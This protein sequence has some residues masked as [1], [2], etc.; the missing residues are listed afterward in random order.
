MLEPERD[1][2][3]R[4]VRGGRE[5]TVIG[6]NRRKPDLTELLVRKSISGEE[7]DEDDWQFTCECDAGM[8]SAAPSKTEVE[9]TMTKLSLESNLSYGGS[10]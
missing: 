3:N 4:A 6:V 5:P 10:Q 8:I 2:T 9:D 1:P 7:M